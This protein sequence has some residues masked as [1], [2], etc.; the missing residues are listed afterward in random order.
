MIIY[1]NGPENKKITK[2]LIDRYRIQNVWVAS[3]HL[4]SNAVIER[5]HQQIVDDL[6][7]L[8]PKWV[9]NLPFVLWADRITTRV[10]TGFTP[11][12]LVL[13]QDCI[14]PVEL[15][16][17]SWTI[18]EW[19]KVKTTAELLA[20]RAR[21]LERREEDREEAQENVRKSRLR[22]NV[23][24]DKNH[25]ERVQ[26]MEIE[27]MVLLYNS[28]LDKQWSQKLKNKWLGPYKIS[29]IGEIG[30]YLPNELDG[31]ELPGIFA[32]DRIKKF[33]AGY[34]VEDIKAEVPE[35]NV[36]AVE[37]LDEEPYEMVDVEL[38]TGMV[39]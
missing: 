13:G 33:F 1:D 2:I 20:A 18:I 35:E 11:Y 14:L 15:Y 27:D 25:W 32:E 38:D 34:G 17:S 26:T 16:A 23:Y 37:E 10:S 19:R 36:E 24:F 6:A 7:K 9:K 4:Q 5:G 28:S 29:E 31:T 21:Q 22:N 39:W 8:G 12:R 3:Y 30:T